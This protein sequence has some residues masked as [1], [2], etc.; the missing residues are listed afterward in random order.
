MQI[1]L[2]LILYYLNNYLDYLKDTLLFIVNNTDNSVS[3]QVINTYFIDNNQS[4]DGLLINID[5]STKNKYENKELYINGNQY[6]I[7]SQQQI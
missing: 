3:S 4:I 7:I 6:V 1:H 5:D 2:I